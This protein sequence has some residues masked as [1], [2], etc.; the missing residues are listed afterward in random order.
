MRTSIDPLATLAEKALG[1]AYLDFSE[2]FTR[3]EAFHVV[4]H[5]GIEAGLP[6]IEVRLRGPLNEIVAAYAG[7]VPDLESL[8]EKMRCAVRARKHADTALAIHA[9]TVVFAHAIL[10]RLLHDLL[11]ILG[12]TLVSAIAPR[13][14]EKKVR[15]GDL[16]SEAADTLE[17]R[18]VAAHIRD[19]FRESLEKKINF[20][21]S[22]C[23]FRADCQDDGYRYDQERLLQLD[24]DRQNLLHHAVLSSREQ[25][26]SLDLPFVQNTGFFF[27]N[28]V[29]ARL[30]ATVN[31]RAML[32]PYLSGSGSA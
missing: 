6:A 31:L 24:R 26:P 10:E 11:Q 27:I 4:S 15:L 20:L 16:R 13:L 28:L 32:E 12:E 9:A 19:L 30:N 14:A 7:K 1:K 3:L 22:V 23:D 18:A 2:N 5:A 21:F 29:A 25:E 8:A 17:A